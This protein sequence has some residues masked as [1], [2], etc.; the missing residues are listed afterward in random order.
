MAI[1]SARLN[2][3]DAKLCLASC[4]ARPTLRPDSLVN[5]GGGSRSIR[6]V[7]LTRNVLTDISRRTSAE[8]GMRGLLK[9]R[10]AAVAISCVVLV[11]RWS[12]EVKR[13]L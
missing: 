7:E 5:C 1:L 9:G 8:S 3:K 13:R 12:G 6:V 4:P 2:R 10:R 11:L